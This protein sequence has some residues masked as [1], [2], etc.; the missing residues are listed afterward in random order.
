M[1]MLVYIPGI[2]GTLCT[3]LVASLAEPAFAAVKQDRA[4]NLQEGFA[5]EA[6]WR[7]NVDGKT[8]EKRFNI[9]HHV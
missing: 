7:H 1:A 4:R 5:E 8:I 6:M 2:V 3:P 9:G